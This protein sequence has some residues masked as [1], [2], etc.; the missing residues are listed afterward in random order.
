MSENVRALEIQTYLN[1]LQPPTLQLLLS[2]V[3]MRRVNLTVVLSTSKISQRIDEPEPN[4]MLELR[5]Q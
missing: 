2:S 5:D 1:H 3:D 4:P